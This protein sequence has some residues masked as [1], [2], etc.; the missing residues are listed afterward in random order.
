MSETTRKDGTNFWIEVTSGMRWER[1]L[2]EGI[3][4]AAPNRTRYQTFFA[5]MNAGDLVLHYLTSALTRQK[6][7]RSRVVA[8]SRVASN[9]TVNEKRII[10][11]CSNTLMLPNPV[12]LDELRKLERKSPLLQKLVVNLRMQRYLSQIS[13][14]DFEAI[15][16]VHPVNLRRFSKS[17]LGKWLKTLRQTV[18]W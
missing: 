3:V 2:K 17:R 14:S 8:I 16:R 12:S 4:L 7:L 10:A 6:E 9:P 18:A 15:L 11:P 1:M 5:G 13:P